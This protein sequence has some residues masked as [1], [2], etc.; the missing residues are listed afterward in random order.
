MRPLI[1]IIIPAFNHEKYIGE[2]ISSILEQSYKNIELIVIDDGSTDNTWRIICDYAEKDARVKSFRQEN[3][4]VGATLARAMDSASGEW[5]T[6]CGSDDSMP[7]DAISCL[8]SKCE[9]NDLVIAEYETVKDSGERCHVRL[10]C[11]KDLPSLIYQS[12]AAWAKLYRKQFLDEHEINYPELSVEEDTVFLSCL[13][14][15]HPRYTVVRKAVYNYWEHDLGEKS[16]TRRLSSKLYTDRAVGKS[17]ALNNMLE[18]GYRE[19]YERYYF[20]YAD[21][22]LAQ[23][24]EMF[25]SESR[26][27][28]MDTYRKFILTNYHDTDDRRL[29]LLTGMSRAEFEQTD[30]SA[31]FLSKLSLDRRDAVANM[32]ALGQSGLK[33]IVRYCR[34]W[35][36]Y[37]VRKREF[38]REN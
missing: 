23:L 21:Q 29:E 11:R 14:K 34:L 24:Q 20:M 4:G 27:S 18:G 2:T 26:E 8:V 32:Y 6:F 3:R 28:C 36:E 16:L 30:Y 35:F 25:D 12:G 33:Y 5:L 15:N 17:T 19:A 10:E 31:F 37:K 38:K 1:S 13:L 7:E 22:L 9:G